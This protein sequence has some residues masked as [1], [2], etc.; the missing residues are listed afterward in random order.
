MYIL[1]NYKHIVHKHG[2]A[3]KI[4]VTTIQLKIKNGFKTDFFYTLLFISEWKERTKRNLAFYS[5]W[6]ME[7]CTQIVHIVYINCTLCTNID[8]HLYY[9]VPT[10][11]KMF[12]YYVLTLHLLILLLTKL[13]EKKMLFTEFQVLYKMYK[14]AWKPVLYMD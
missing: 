4:C 13:N 12:K 14:P 2:E 9:S 1:K 3:K 11:I 5:E 8:V 10:I 7:K 6:I